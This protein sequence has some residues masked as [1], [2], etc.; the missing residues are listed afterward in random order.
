MRHGIIVR[1]LHL[2]SKTSFPLALNHHVGATATCNFSSRCEVSL[3]PPTALQIPCESLILLFN[4]SIRSATYT[5]LRR[6]FS[7][8]FMDD[9]FSIPSEGLLISQ[10]LGVKT[11]LCFRPRRLTQKPHAVL[12]RVE[13]SDDSSDEGGESSSLVHFKIFAQKRFT[14]TPGK[15]ILLTVDD[16]RLK[17]HSV[18]FCGA[19][20]TS[21]ELEMQ[22]RVKAAKEGDIPPL[23]K[24]TLP[25]KMRRAW[26]KKTDGKWY[27]QISPH[28][29]PFM[30]C[31][32][33]CNYADIRWHSSN[34]D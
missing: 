34:P 17:D 10:I 22:E 18:L 26:V 25:P 2:V 33:A 23:P 6:A 12:R 9:S 5:Q 16:A 19:P 21:D 32:W 24:N 11:S 20:L 27:V 3:H 28:L 7:T 14:I 13:A 30:P 29:I 4:W 8:L 31:R 1:Q 15:E